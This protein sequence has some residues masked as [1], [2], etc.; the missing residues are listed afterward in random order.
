MPR[1]FARHEQFLRI[2]TLLEILSTARQPLDDQSL[3]GSLKERL[4]LTRL[5][6]RTLRRDC[7]FLTSCGYAVDHVPL[8]DGRRFGWMLAK[9]AVGGRRI[10]AEPLTLL[11]L[12]AFA[13]C[14]ELLRP[15]EGTILWTGIESLRHKLERDMP[16]LLGERLETV[17]RVLHVRGFDARYAARPRLISTLSAA[18]TDAREI[19]VEIDGQPL[20]RRRLHPHRIVIQPATVSLLAFPADGPADEPHVLIDIARI[21]G[22]TLLDST[23]TPRDA[24]PEDLLA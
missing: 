22:V 18:I 7:D 24:D 8:P 9:D 3:I 16:A 20:V 21:R 13:V 2:F 11:E 23:F 10:P 1:N 5:S 12:T 15:V 17:K 4:G 6:P 14:R 19:D